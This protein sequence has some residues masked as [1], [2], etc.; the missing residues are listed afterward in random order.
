M[1]SP[2][3]KG[4]NLRFSNEMVAKGRVPCAP[5]DKIKGFYGFCRGA[6]Q[7]LRQLGGFETLRSPA[8]NFILGPAAGVRRRGATGF[9]VTIEPPAKSRLRDHFSVAWIIFQ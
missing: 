4:V 7:Q 3:L 5:I 8:G 2:T 9:Q 1:T 6:L